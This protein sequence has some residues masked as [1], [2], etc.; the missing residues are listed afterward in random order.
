LTRGET[1]QMHAAQFTQFELQRRFP[2][3]PHDT[4]MRDR[5]L[6]A[7]LA[8]PRGTVDMRAI[9]RPAL[10][11][12]LNESNM[13]RGI[14]AI[15]NFR[16]EVIP[17]NFN[18]DGLNDALI[19]V[20]YPAEAEATADVLYEDFIAV[21]GGEDGSW[22]LLPAE[23]AIP[24]AP[25]GDVLAVTLVRSGDLNNDSRDEIA[26]SID[27][28]Q[29]NKRLIIYGW[30]NGA[31]IDLAQPGEIIAY[32]EIVGWP[33]GSPNLIVASFRQESDRWN[34]V[35]EIPVT[36]EYRNNFY[37]PT[38]AMNAQ[39]TPR[40]TVGCAMMA[41]EPLYAQPTADAITQVEAVLNDDQLDL[42][43]ADR[44]RMALAM[45]YT[46]NDQRALAEQQAATLLEDTA[47]NPWLASQ[48][49]AFV[50]AAADPAN[51]P[52]QVCGEL[53]RDALQ[54]FD[55]G[56]AAA[57][58]V[59]QVVRQMFRESPVPRAGSLE[60]NL[61]AMGLPVQETVTVAQVGFAN[62]QV[63]NFAL[64]GASWW[65]F[66]PTDPEFYV[67]LPTN[68]PVAFAA[69]TQPEGPIAPPEHVV[70]AM[71]G[72]GD[73]P[74]ALTAIE[75][76]SQQN[77]QRP[78]SAEAR[79]IQA[80]ASDLLNDRQRARQAYFDLWRDFGGTTW[81]QLAGVHLELR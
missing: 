38:L 12:L 77:P 60:D 64:P 16:V 47:D 50:I 66:A 55:D 18:G 39:F 81:G 42:Q 33:T 40:D 79:Y 11:D 13:R 51:N 14:A 75:N 5:L 31:L 2:G 10:I 1:D 24:A 34:C 29:L 36:W 35:A 74:A 46:L 53:M 70:E 7:M 32:G 62:R 8:A 17:L 63:V 80:L 48:L 22:R 3:A 37:R 58:D 26:L 57:C 19:H 68:P 72:T 67:A 6:D 30:R 78:L 76:L 45:L 20:N 27:D 41:A 52:I 73:L 44:A 59:D 61:R 15:D 23:P 25:Y 49:D 21:I 65:A 56:S 9:A 28:G 71:T 69:A 4:A 43:G 54:T